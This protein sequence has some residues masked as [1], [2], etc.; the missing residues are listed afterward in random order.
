MKKLCITILILVLAIIL[1]GCG[2]NTVQPPL[3]LDDQEDWITIQEGEINITET[4]SPLDFIYEAD[5]TTYS[6]RVLLDDSYIYLKQN[7]IKGHGFYRHYFA[8]NKIIYLGSIDDLFMSS[9]NIVEIDNKLYFYVAV[10]NADKKPLNMLVSI[11]LEKNSIA[12]H[13]L[14][15]DAV[16]GMRSFF[17]NE[18]VISKQDIVVDD[19]FLTSII[20]YD[21]K[22]DAFS[23][24]LKCSYNSTTNEGSAIVTVFGDEDKLYAL[25]DE[26]F[27]G[28]GRFRRVINVYDKGYNL[29]E[30]IAL[31]SDALNYSLSYRTISMM[32]IGDYVY[33]NNVSNYAIIGKIVDVKLEIVF[34]ERY[35]YPAQTQSFNAEEMIFFVR[36]S[37][38]YHKL[39]FQT[40]VLEEINMVIDA[41]DTEAEYQLV[42]FFERNGKILM[43]LENAGFLYGGE[44]LYK[45]YYLEEADFKKTAFDFS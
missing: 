23:E 32:V 22:N 18:N 19:V 20:E 34:E 16:P 26:Y 6:E 15:E 28:K 30:T 38:K 2:S 35:L 39:N 25:T 12:E 21:V 1:V 13:C 36:H 40:G 24:K 7:S 42:C 8:D 9:A 5:K 29:T 11:D 27:G 33:M 14:I 3:D 41:E 4:A 10:K 17:F 44:N 45:K 37:L 31:S 43:E